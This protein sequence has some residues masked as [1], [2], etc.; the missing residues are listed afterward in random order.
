MIL[1]P[2]QEILDV[3][4]GIDSVEATGRDDAL[5]DGE[6]LGA[7]F[8][9]GKEEVLS[10]DSDRSQVPLGEVIVERQLGIVEEATERF[11]LV[12]CVG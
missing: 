7:L 6:V 2:D 11:S 10:P 8:V 4:V 5:E 9:T 12:C 1:D 3:L